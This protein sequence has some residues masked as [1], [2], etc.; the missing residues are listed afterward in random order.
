M[1]TSIELPELA[2]RSVST[3]NAAADSPNPSFP[4]YEPDISAPATAA[5]L[6]P[7]DTGK[8]AWLF[9][10]AATIAETLV[11]GLRAPCPYLQRLALTR[12]SFRKWRLALVL[13]AG[14]V[15]GRNTPT[16]P[17]HHFGDFAVR[18]E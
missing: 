5:S 10:A 13:A 7:V 18:L 1:A 11:W 14:N 12:R 8:D 6:P 9:L 3:I 17:D 2:L 16:R 4:N 15:P